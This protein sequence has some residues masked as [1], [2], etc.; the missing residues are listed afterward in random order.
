MIFLSTYG[1]SQG[2]NAG[3]GHLGFHPWLWANRRRSD[4]RASGDAPASGGDARVP[5]PSTLAPRRSIPRL[6]GAASCS[7]WHIPRR[8]PA[9]PGIA[10]QLASPGLRLLSPVAGN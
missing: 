3:V 4:A 9:V 7:T 2:W 1:A 8:R 10:V 5:G 6:K